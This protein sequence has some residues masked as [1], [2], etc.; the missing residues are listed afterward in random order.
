MKNVVVLMI[1]IASM[2]LFSSCISCG[3]N[4]DSLYDEEYWNSVG[5]EKAMRKAGLTSRADIEK[6]ERQSRLKK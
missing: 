1:V 2:A 4:D 6:D 5:R 3:G